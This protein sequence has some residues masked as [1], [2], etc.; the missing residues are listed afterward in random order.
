MSNMTLYDAYTALIDRV[1]FIRAEYE[2]NDV[3]RETSERL[4]KHRDALSP[5]TARR[6]WT[7]GKL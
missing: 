4:A 1:E 5:E 7:G 6:L 3:L 2:D